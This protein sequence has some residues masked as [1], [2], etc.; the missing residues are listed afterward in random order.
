MGEIEYDAA[1]NQFL[2]VGIS[3]RS[4]MRISKEFTALQNGLIVNC[5]SDPNDSSDFPGWAAFM[6]AAV[7]AGGCAAIRANGPE[8]IASIKE[9]VKIPV[10]GFYKANIPGYSVSITPTINHA[11]MVAAAGADFIELDGTQTP[12]P[13]GKLVEEIITKTKQI[14]GMPVIADITTSMDGILAAN[15]GVDAVMITIGGSSANGNNGDESDY[16]LLTTL[17]KRLQIPIIAKGRLYTPERARKA[18]DCGA[19]AVVVGSAITRPQMIVSHFTSALRK[20]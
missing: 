15:M 8:D 4:Q 20:S 6:A 11:Q 18:L 17:S 10:I 16:S 1:S 13:E 9:K 7:T 5:I 3:M 2:K 19:F 14:T 12:H